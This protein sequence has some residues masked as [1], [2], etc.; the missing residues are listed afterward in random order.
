MDSMNNPQSAFFFFILVW[1]EQCP[2]TNAAKTDGI[3]GLCGKIAMGN[4]CLFVKFIAPVF[5]LLITTK[6]S[7]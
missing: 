1:T 7:S 6:S 2:S 4:I 3:C 5:R